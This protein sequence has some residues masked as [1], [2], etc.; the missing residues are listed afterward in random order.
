M[1]YHL[2]TLLIAGIITGMI[3]PLALAG[4]WYWVQYWP[5]GRGE[6]LSYY[7]AVLPARILAFGYE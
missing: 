5:G 4:V 2:R 1:R 3:G 6:S 7:F